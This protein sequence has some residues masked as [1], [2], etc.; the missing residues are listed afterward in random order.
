M[1]HLKDITKQKN[2]FKRFNLAKFQKKNLKRYKVQLKQIQKYKKY[3]KIK[4]W[5]LLSNKYNKIHLK[6]NKYFRIHYSKRDLI[7]QLQLASL[8]LSEV[9]DNSF[10]NISQFYF[11]AII[12]LYINSTLFAFFL[13]DNF[14]QPIIFNIFDNLKLDLLFSFIFYLFIFIKYFN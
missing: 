2:T 7:F 3:Y 6:H 12:F 8:D 14:I 11:I 9:Y 10:I 13:M 5:L 4:E 1:K